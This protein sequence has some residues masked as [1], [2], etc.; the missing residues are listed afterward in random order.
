[1]G[2]FH[3]ELPS[4]PES[5]FFFTVPLISRFL[6]QNPAQKNSEGKITVDGSEPFITPQSRVSCLPS[7]YK[8]GFPAGAGRHLLTGTSDSW[9]F[10]F[11]RV[12]KGRNLPWKSQAAGRGWGGGQ[13]LPVV[14]LPGEFFLQFP[15]ALPGGRYLSQELNHLFVLGFSKLHNLSRV[16]RWPLQA[17]AER[18]GTAGAGGKN[19][20]A[21]GASR[22]RPPPSGSGGFGETRQPKET[23]APSLR[24]RATAKDEHS[25]AAL[26]APPSL[27][28][29]ARLGPFPPGWKLRGRRVARS[30]R[31]KGTVGL[32]LTLV[33][34]RLVRNLCYPSGE[35]NFWYLDR[36]ERRRYWLHRLPRP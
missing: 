23:P 6:F 35:C 26:G 36:I 24:L 8:N 33:A 17:V 4:E 12:K 19:F 14:D 1:M 7:R 10:H 21:M 20:L 32:I 25:C 30:E 29:R 15:Q 13:R 5:H 28:R 18:K 9:L 3:F 11:L 16:R 22:F 27:A 2:N 31:S 34:G